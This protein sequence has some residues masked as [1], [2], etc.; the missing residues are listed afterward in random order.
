MELKKE[1]KQ[2]AANIEQ[3][4]QDIKAYK[5][6]QTNLVKTVNKRDQDLETLKRE[7]KK[8]VADVEQRD[9]DIKDLKGIIEQREN[10]LSILKKRASS[11]KRSVTIKNK[12]FEELNS[13]HLALENTVTSLEENLIQLEDILAQ[14]TALSDYKSDQI[15]EILGSRSWRVLSLPR[16]LSTIWRNKTLYL[17]KFLG[18]G[19]IKSDYKNLADSSTASKL[20]TS[21]S[22][23]LARQDLAASRSKVLHSRWHTALLGVENNLPDNE[24][25]NIT[26]SAVTFNSEKWL[27]NFFMS[28]VNLDYPPH[29]ITLHFVDNGSTDHGV[30]GIESFI[31][32]NKHRYRNIEIFRRPNKGYGVGN[33]YGIRQSSDD[34]V[35]VTNVDTEFY[36]DSLKK[37]VAVAVN[38]VADV[39]CWEFRQTPYE[40]PKFYDPITFLTNWTSHACVLIRKKAYLA[41]GGYDQKIFM[42]GEDV[43]LSYRFRAH[44][45]KLR[46]VPSA[47]IKH[48]VD[49][50]DST[51]R[52]NQLSGSV[53]ANILLRYRYGS[54]SD[55]IAGETLF[56][57]VK[58]NEKDPIRMKAWN[59]VNKIV[60]KNRWHFFKKRRHRSKANFPFHE[61]DYDIIRPGANVKITP[62]KDLYSKDLPKVSVITRTHGKA[63]EHLEN[64]ITSVLNQ[65]YKNIEHII[66]EDRT[67]DGQD[68]VTP[69]TAKYGNRIKYLK[70]DGSGRSHC[71]NYG[72]LRANGDY[73]C[74]LDN[75]DIFYADH[76][77]T[78]VVNIINKPD[79]VCSYSLAWDALSE[80][81]KGQIS[82]TKFLL[83]DAHNHPY[84]KQ[85][86][87]TENFIPIQAIIFKK[88]LFDKYGGFR[89]SFSQLEDWNLWVRYAQLGPFAF[90]PK[91]TS[92]YRTPLAPDIRQKRH[93]MLHAAYEGVKKTNFDDIA[94]V[95]QKLKTDRLLQKSKSRKAS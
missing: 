63:R 28:I 65:T 40:H 74:W 81:K 56:A 67:D 45:W 80:T 93:S 19:N 15:N 8:F 61:F 82:E 4:D 95:R 50:E 14:E 91:V 43:E 86:L 49:L 78:L 77:E 34:F 38:D 13:E 16:K 90:T 10:D 51:L 30:K 7:R 23:H 39:A 44:G 47:V 52:P 83:H 64:A 36:S 88:T 18:R 5:K 24:L 58:A 75:D 94:E 17:V 33:D 53:A 72:A 92:F 68:V 41:V 2:F 79:A 3:R 76:I 54:Y 1:R 20:S 12:K 62:F 66:V 27:W 84:D 11:L 57:A 29:K 48:Y 35:L 32:T 73:L 26:I 85:R 87:L 42:Y 31:A 70:S 37:A 9:Q 46:Y 71:G 22:N 6:E 89:E 21:K 59:Q 25:P 60:N 69:L 55:I